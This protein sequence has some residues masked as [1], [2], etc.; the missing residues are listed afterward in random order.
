MKG[1]LG[2]ETCAKCGK[3]GECTLTR[4]PKQLVVY[5]GLELWHL[6]CR[7]KANERRAEIPESTRSSRE[8]TVTFDADT[9]T[10]RNKTDARDYYRRIL[11]RKRLPSEIAEQLR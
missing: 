11:R 8:V 4:G 3:K 10:H 7:N 9:R 5:N 6:A 1:G 2:G